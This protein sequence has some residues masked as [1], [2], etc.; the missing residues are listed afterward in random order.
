LFS[1][2]NVYVNTIINQIP[3]YLSS[4]DNVSL[5]APFAIDEFKIVLFQ[6]DSNKSPGP[7]GL[8]LAFYKRNL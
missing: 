8:S 5:L 6:M 1:I 7:D 3:S 4:N 2:G